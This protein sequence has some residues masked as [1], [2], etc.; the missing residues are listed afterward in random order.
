MFVLSSTSLLLL[1]VSCGMS[2]TGSWPA[3]SF[4][5]SPSSLPL[6]VV[7]F[8]MIQK[9]MASAPTRQLGTEHST[10]VTGTAI[11]IAYPGTPDDESVNKRC[12]VQA[13]SDYS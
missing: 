2:Y 6:H 8:L 3:K 4:T 1:P 9:Y 12:L 10:A 7:F 11:A 13:I 5:L